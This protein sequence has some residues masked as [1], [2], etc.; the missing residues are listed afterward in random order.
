MTNNLF[1]FFYQVRDWFLS[2]NDEILIKTLRT[3]TV[4]ILMKE[5]SNLYKT[6]IYI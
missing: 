6:T 2:S 5:S 1:I 3:N 4:L